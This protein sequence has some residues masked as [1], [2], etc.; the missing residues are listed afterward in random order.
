MGVGWNTCIRKTAK[1]LL[2]NLPEACSVCHMI[3]KIGL[4]FLIQLYDSLSIV[5]ILMRFI[6]KWKTEW[7]WKDSWLV[8]LLSEKV[9]FYGVVLGR[10][11][12]LS[13]KPIDG[14]AIRSE[15]IV[16]INHSESWRAKKQLEVVY[17]A[18]VVVVLFSS[19]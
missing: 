13:E 16:T 3:T 17:A 11:A 10:N 4:D 5:T 1:N 8:N 14:L 7:S 9:F 19:Y 18:G 12:V 6:D 2:T 15:E